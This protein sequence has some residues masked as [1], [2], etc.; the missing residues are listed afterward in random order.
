MKLAELQKKLADY[1]Y[2]ARPSDAARN[3]MKQ[4]LSTETAID[5]DTGLELYRK[6]LVFGII[7]CL[8]GV[9]AQTRRVLGDDNFAFFVRE[10]IYQAPSTHEDV[11]QYGAHLPAF[12]AER[13]ELADSRWI[14]D[15]A[16]IEWAWHDLAFISLDTPA[17]VED[18]LGRPASVHMIHAL[19]TLKSSWPL[20]KIWKSLQDESEH[21]LKELIVLEPED[22]YYC[23]W[24]TAAGLKATEISPEIWQLLHDLKAGMNPQELARQNYTDHSLATT[25][26]MLAYAAEQGWLKKSN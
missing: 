6:N 17:R 8:Q 14:G 22:S 1:I 11:R 23:L 7:D 16:A 20:L 26:E 21:Q 15:M 19:H 5:P 10:L 25:W 2:S 18:I 4:L 9:F 3:E 24:R 12:L 13:A